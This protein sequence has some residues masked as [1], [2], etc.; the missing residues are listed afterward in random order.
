MLY[1]C[2]SCEWEANCH[3][4]KEMAWSEKAQRWVCDMCFDGG[5]YG[6]PGISLTSELA[7]RD[8][9][10]VELAA[11][12]RAL[13]VEQEWR[14][15]SEAPISEAPKDGTPVL[16]TN[17]EAGGSWVA[18]YCEHAQSGWRFDN[19]WHS[20]LLNHDYL[21]NKRRSYEPTHWQPLPTPPMSNPTT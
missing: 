18:Y 7:A 13:K 8:A 9:L 14:P 19:P 20:F 1:M 3:E 17:E 11:N 21:P 5:D 12:G 10:K 15:I 4:P 2:E 6:Q 16:V